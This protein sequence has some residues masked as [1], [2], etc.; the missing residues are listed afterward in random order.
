MMT[1]PDDDDEEEE[2]VGQLAHQPDCPVCN[3]DPLAEFWAQVLSSGN[4][5][6]NSFY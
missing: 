6:V 4:L 2:G 1:I 5:G 3:K